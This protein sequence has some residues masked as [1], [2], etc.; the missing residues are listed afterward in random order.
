[1]SSTTS[2]NLLTD[3]QVAPLLGLKD[4]TLRS[5][6][7]RGVG[8]TYVKLGLGPGAACRYAPSDIEA[9]I[10]QGRHIPSVRAAWG[11]NGDL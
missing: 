3:K 5:W 7:C 10:V 4:S 2:N 6:R 1:M 9:F 11:K 8:P